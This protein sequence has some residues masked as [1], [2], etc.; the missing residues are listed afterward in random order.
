MEHVYVK[1]APGGRVRQPERGS[2]VM[3]EKG[4]WVPRDTYYERL[5][6]T[7]DVVLSPDD[8]PPREDVPDEPAAPQTSPKTEAPVPSGRA[9]RATPQEG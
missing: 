4:D 3:P 2:R 8:A 7:G 6:I 9:R 5:I 1:P